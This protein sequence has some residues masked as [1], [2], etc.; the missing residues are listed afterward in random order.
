MPIQCRHL[1]GTSG[2]RRGQ[3]LAAQG[4]E[5][6]LLPFVDIIFDDTLQQR[7]VSLGTFIQRHGQSLRYDARDRLG[8]IGIDEQRT[9]A[10]DGGAGKTRENE[11][12]GIFWI[13]RSDVRAR[14]TAQ[15]STCSAPR[16][17]RSALYRGVQPPS[18]SEAVERNG[19][20]WPIA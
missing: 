9:F 8:I 2:L 19:R 18:I 15:R 10:V 13:L 12:A 16:R 14:T 20:S 7:R 11:Y 4:I 1:R 5:E 17:G 3:I 6:V